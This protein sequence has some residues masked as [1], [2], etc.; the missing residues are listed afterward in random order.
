MRLFSMTVAGALMILG[1]FWRDLARIEPS[2]TPLAGAIVAIIAG[3]VIDW[4]IDEAEQA[5]E[6]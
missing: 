5:E 6:E 2:L 1:Y 4:R 3:Y